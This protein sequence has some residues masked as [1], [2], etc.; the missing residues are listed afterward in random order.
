MHFTNQEFSERVGILEEEELEKLGWEC[1]NGN[2]ICYSRQKELVEFVEKLNSQAIQF[3][4]GGK[5]KKYHIATDLD[6]CELEECYRED[7]GLDEEAQVVGCSIVNR[8]AYVNRLDFFLCDGDDDE[9]LY[10]EEVEEW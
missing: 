3:I 1:D 5:P 7:K 10:L 8:I 6:P 2:R 9:D 4:K